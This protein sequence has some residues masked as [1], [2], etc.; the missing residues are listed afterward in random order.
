MT[1]LVVDSTFCARL[2]DLQEL[3]ELCDESGR[4]L[5]YFHPAVPGGKTEGAKVQS[6]FTEEEIRQRQQQRTGRPL[7]EILEDLERS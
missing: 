5:G 1:K 7:K 3:V 6:P 2:T 4:T